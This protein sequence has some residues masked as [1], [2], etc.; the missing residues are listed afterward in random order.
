MGK[1]S[2]SSY[3]PFVILAGFRKDAIRAL[4][5]LSIDYFVY[6]EDHKNKLDLLRYTHCVGLGTI[7]PSEDKLKNKKVHLIAVT[8]EGVLLAQEI[9]PKIDPNI[10]LDLFV[11]VSDKLIMK[12]KLMLKKIP[13][14]DFLKGEKSIVIEKLQEKW[15]KK[16]VIKRRVGSGSRDLLVSEN[17]EELKNALTEEKI[18]EKYIPHRVESS[19]ESFINDTKIIFTNIT[20][21]IRHGKINLVPGDF[22]NVE[23]KMILDLNKSV[24]QALDIKS[25]MTHLEFFLTDDNKIL[26]G[27]IAWRPPGGHIMKLISESYGIDAWEIFFKT[28]L[29]KNIEINKTPHTSSLSVILHPGFGRVESIEG[30]DAVEYSPYLSRKKLKIKK[31]EVVKVRRGLGEEVGHFILKGTEFEIKA[32]LEKIEKLLIIKLNNSGI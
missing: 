23:K 8:E 7:L 32:E 24:I 4:E 9:A 2:N 19:V 18:I 20:R 6:F 11:S 14:T 21:Y 31:G 27:E 3:A 16:I 15:G 10:D 26:L 5:R 17:P 22:N 1:A 28:F 29:E 25:G 12:E 30:W 13:M